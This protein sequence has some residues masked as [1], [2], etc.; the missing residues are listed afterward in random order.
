M[1]QQSKK[2]SLDPRI[3]YRGFGVNVACMAPTTAIQISVNKTLE[4][5]FAR[6]DVLSTTLRAFAAGAISALA[7]SPT[8]LIVLTQQNEGKNA[9]KTI[10]GLISQEGLAVLSR[11]FVA[12]S[13]RD[14]GFGVGFLSM[15]PWLNN[16]IRNSVIDNEP[17]ALIGAG[18]IGGAGT[19]IATHPFDTIST[20]MQADYKQKNIKSFRQAIKTIYITEGLPAFFKGVTPR[21]T[22]VA[23]AIPLMHSVKQYLT[24][25]TDT[26]S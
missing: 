9:Y 16:K 7:S 10:R 25:L 20:R 24:T 3:L 26:N 6:N 19:A 2:V 4:E 8:E 11:G 23:L 21:G 15:Y 12:K 5:K 22:R 1:L 18:V 14:G 13:L 17:L